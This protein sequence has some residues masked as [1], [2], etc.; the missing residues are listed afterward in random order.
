MVSTD[1]WVNVMSS[2]F[3]DLMK[4]MTVD[5]SNGNG[6]KVDTLLLSLQPTSNESEGATTSFMRPDRSVCFCTFE[7]SALLLICSPSTTPFST[8]S[9][10][11]V[12]TRRVRPKRLFPS[13]YM[14]L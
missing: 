1:N 14:S 4:V 8:P 6:F 2:V 9:L 7:L 10:S 3:N 13:V 12:V 11:S 5:S